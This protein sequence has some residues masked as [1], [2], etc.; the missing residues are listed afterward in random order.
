VPL[1][2]GN[3][4]AIATIRAIKRCGINLAFIPNLLQ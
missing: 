3:I 4:R 1:K 2:S